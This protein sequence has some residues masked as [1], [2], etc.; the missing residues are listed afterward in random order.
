MSSTTGNQRFAE[1]PKHSAKAQIHS[2]KNLPS[3]ALG[4]HDSAKKDSAKRSLPS[5][6]CRA[7]GED[8]AVCL[9]DTRQTIFEKH[10]KKLSSPRGQPGAPRRRRP[11]RRPAGATSPPPT[12]EPRAAALAGLGPA[13]SGHR[14]RGPSCC[15]AAA[16]KAQSLPRRTLVAGDAACRGRAARRQP[17]RCIAATGGRAAIL[18][19]LPRPSR[20]RTVAQRG[21]RRCCAARRRP[22]RCRTVRRWPEMPPAACRGRR[23]RLPRPCAARRQPSRCLTAR[24]GPS[25]CRAARRGSAVHHGLRRPLPLRPSRGA[26]LAMACP[27][28]STCHSLRRPPGEDKGES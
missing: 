17:S 18:P 12:R 6:S 8:F 23:C 21:P 15:R 4:K 25:R 19:P 27:G 11:C 13:P 7:L 14:H 10:K 20:C 5:V 26:P 22:S 3:V 28:R 24:R 1:C 9:V 16:A 2:A